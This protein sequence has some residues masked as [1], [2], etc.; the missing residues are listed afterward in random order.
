MFP[1]IGRD[2]GRPGGEGSTTEGEQRSSIS[3]Q[4][5]AGAIGARHRLLYSDLSSLATEYRSGVLTQR[6]LRPERAAIERRSSP[7]AVVAAG[8]ATVA[9]S[10]AAESV[11]EMDLKRISADEKCG[12]NGRNNHRELSV[13]ERVINDRWSLFVKPQLTTVT[14]QLHPL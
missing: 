11:S 5:H 7:A 10:A 12:R 6:D 8:L 4:G 2:E 1:E 3:G 9:C 13:F 14:N